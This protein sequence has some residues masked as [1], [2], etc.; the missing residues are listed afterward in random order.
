MFYTTQ[1]VSFPHTFATLPF[2]KERDLTIPHAEL[3]RLH[4]T[5]FSS[6]S[7]SASNINANDGQLSH[8]Y[9]GL[10]MKCLIVLYDFHLHRNMQKN[11]VKCE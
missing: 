5:L 3:L 11:L 6:A 1:T 9:A 8:K 2:L 7:P 4:G 10:H